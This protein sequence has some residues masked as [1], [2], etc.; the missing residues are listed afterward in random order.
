MY[1]YVQFKYSLRLSMA[2]G[3]P[4]CRCPLGWVAKKKVTGVRAF[5][6]EENETVLNFQKLFFLNVS[7]K[8]EKCVKGFHIKTDFLHFLC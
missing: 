5:M 2:F 3:T 1:T 4:G 6:K 7:A 8:I